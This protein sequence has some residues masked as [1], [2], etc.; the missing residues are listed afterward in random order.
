M[1]AIILKSEF[2]DDYGLPWTINIWDKEADT[3]VGEIAYTPKGSIIL[4]DEGDDND[5]F[6]RI[7]PKKLAWT[8]LMHAHDYTT[9]QREAIF[10]F[11]S[12]LT[13]SPEG[14]YY[15]ELIQDTKRIFRGKILADVGDLTLDYHRALAL[16]A[17]DGMLQLKDVAYRPTDY[18]DKVPETLIKKLTFVEHITEILHRN[19][20]IDFFYNQGL[21]LGEIPMFTT[22]GNWTTE[23]ALDTPG[24]IFTYVAKKNT[25][26]KQD[27]GKAYREY[28]SCYNAL[29]DILTGFNMRGYFSDGAYHFEQ[30]G[31]QDNLT[32]IR[33]TYDYDGAEITSVGNKVTHNITT[34]DDIYVLADPA[35]KH[36]SPFKA[37]TLKQNK[38]YDNLLGGVNLFFKTTG[39]DNRGP[40]ELGYHI[41]AGNQM[42]FDFR[43]ILEID[44]LPFIYGLKFEFQI[45]MGD[46]YL[47]LDPINN[48]SIGL[49]N[50]DEAIFKKYQWTTVP[51]T[52]EMLIPYQVFALGGGGGNLELFFNN[53]SNRWILGITDEIPEDGP[54]T[55]ELVSWIAT[56]SDN[57]TEN[58]S[59][60]PILISW[61]IDKRSRLYIVTNGEEGLTEVPDNTIIYEIGD[62][63]N[64]IVYETKMS[65]FDT[66][67]VDTFYGLYIK[68]TSLVLGDFYLYSTEWTDADMGVTLPIQE[69]MMRQIL[70][71]RKIP[72]KVV[73]ISVERT[74]SELFHMDDRYAIGEDLYI[75]LRMVHNIDQGFY[76]I[77][78]WSPIKDYD[79]V[80]IIKYGDD[81][82][83]EYFQIWNDL[84]Y[85]QV[86]NKLITGYW[87][88]D[89]V[90]D[91]YVTLPEALNFYI[92]TTTE[93]E[94]IEAN[95]DVFKNGV[96]LDYVDYTTLTFP[97]VG[98]EL[99]MAQ[100]TVEVDADKFH[101]AFNE[102]DTIIIKYFKK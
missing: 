11:Y 22:S 93:P 81:T 45:R 36:I 56:E 85:A 65:Y 38:K 69:L 25:Y 82:P 4:T 31:Y 88:F 35:I 50:N 18:D 9:E 64:S 55:I 91:P 40:L 73:R 14:R 72:G 19:D 27:E 49:T 70:G 1:P 23:V 95:F 39:P 5:P 100:Y 80:N 33:Y 101:F 12:G 7:I 84:I 98:G 37:V 96:R 71:M 48:S 77:S 29:L 75:P 13:T 3:F 83:V 74:D 15:V 61:T 30:L 99:T 92:T 10:S 86:G 24:D 54:V 66:T 89:N 26:F 42:I 41:G 53:F 62:V 28:E 16:T 76:Q 68:F 2:Y 47:M 102:G 59:L 97:L 79:G 17:T 58:T 67:D 43:F 52:F 51:S 44:P 87:R 46:Y 6:K 21:F 32:L 34:N 78:L 8:I 60:P 57:V 94:N 20:V 63:R 90:T